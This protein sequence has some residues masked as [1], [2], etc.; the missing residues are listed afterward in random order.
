MYMYSGSGLEE[1]GSGG[2]YAQCGAVVCGMLCAARSA[3]R[4][5]SISISG[6]G[7]LIRVENVVLVG[8]GGPLPRLESCRASTTR[9]LRSAPG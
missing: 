6:H 2:G 4:R 5:L 8:K 1:C 7:E 3:I 9:G